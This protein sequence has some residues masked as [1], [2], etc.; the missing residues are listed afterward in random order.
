MS[1]KEIEMIY[2]HELAEKLYYRIQKIK[3]VLKN[4][5]DEYTYICSLII[6]AMSHI[7]YMTKETD[8]NKIKGLIIETID[9]ILPVIEWQQDL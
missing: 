7:Q 9:T 5:D 1:E 6:S 2:K 3:K 4:T 8:K